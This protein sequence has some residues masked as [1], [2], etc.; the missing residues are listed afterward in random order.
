MWAD[1]KYKFKVSCVHLFIPA[2]TLDRY[3]GHF[4]GPTGEG[5]LRDECRSFA[6]YG[7]SEKVSSTPRVSV[8]AV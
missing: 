2:V 8:L 7:L 5:V 4:L 1:K 6:A 3:F